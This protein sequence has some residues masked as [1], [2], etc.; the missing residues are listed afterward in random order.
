MKISRRNIGQAS[1]FFLAATLLSS[2]NRGYGCPSNFEINDS[3][4]EA[5]QT[6]VSLLF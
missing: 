6:V 3:L 4:I 2:C 1:L 5:V